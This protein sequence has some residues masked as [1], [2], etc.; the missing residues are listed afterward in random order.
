MKQPIIQIKN[1]K[2]G[3][4]ESPFEG[5]FANMVGVNVFKDKGLVQVNE[6]LRS[7]AYGNQNIWAF[8]Y[9]LRS[10]FN[11]T[12]GDKF[13]AVGDLGISATIDY[14]ASWPNLTGFGTGIIIGAAIYK[15]YLVIMHPTNIDFYG[16]LSQEHLA[17]ATWNNARITT[18]PDS[19][20][21]PSFLSTRDDCIY[22]G[23]GRYVSRLQE[24]AGQVFN[25]TNTG[26]YTF[27]AKMMPS[28]L[29][30][31]A[32]IQAISELPQARRLHLMT[33]KGI[34]PYVTTESLADN[35][36]IPTERNV[37]AGVVA[38][39][40]LYFFAGKKP[41]LYVT[42][43]SSVQRLFRFPNYIFS[44]DDG[45]DYSIIDGSVIY[46]GSNILFGTKKGVGSW[47]VENNVF[48]FDAL[49]SR[50]EVTIYSHITPY[51]LCDIGDINNRYFFAFQDGTSYGIDI[52]TFNTYPT[53]VEAYGPY[54]ETGVIDFGNR[55]EGTGIGDIELILGKKMDATYPGT[56][57]VSYRRNIADSWTT[58][59][60]FREASKDRLRC[61]FPLATATNIQ[62]RIDFKY[63]YYHTIKDYMPIKELNIYGR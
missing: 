9:I 53:N 12:Y 8:P 56:I 2:T 37:T 17:G 18:L 43:G 36:I 63:R 32:T 19:Y 57:K 47:D 11:T 38:N 13:F 3:I 7:S 50:G 10:T 27:T 54:I 25:P 49:S 20:L 33:D 59:K 40:K 26:T 45:I 60:E 22:I 1:W 61:P 62:L 28:G 58:I 34:Y 4:S 24:K 35:P 14:G 55:F 15:D 21:H 41:S 48:T 29:P 23:A 52:K 46:N 6:I 42:N 16:P 31:G 30:A 44:Q 5:T 39:D 51:G